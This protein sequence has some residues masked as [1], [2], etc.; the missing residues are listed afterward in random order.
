MRNEAKRCME[1]FKEEYS[2]TVCRVGEVLLSFASG[3]LTVVTFGTSYWLVSST[4]EGT[5]KFHMGLWQNCTS[6]D[7][8]GS[9]QTLPLS[10]SSKAD[11]LLRISHCDIHNYFPSRLLDRSTIFYVYCV[12]CGNVC[13]DHQYHR[14]LT[15][16]TAMA[17]LCYSGICHSG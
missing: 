9:C 12:G 2:D 5:S 7:S 6:A 15:A 16:Q 8:T 11:V 10:G 1:S 3:I 13:L 4:D 17:F 14:T